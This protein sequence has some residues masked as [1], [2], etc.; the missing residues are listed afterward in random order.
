[1]PSILKAGV[2]A[3]MV[4]TGGL[5]PS[6]LLCAADFSEFDELDAQEASGGGGGGDG[7]GGGAAA[8]AGAGASTE[9]DDLEAAADGA[10]GSVAGGVDGVGGEAATSGDG[11][12]DDNE[13]AG[14]EFSNAASAGSRPGRSG[15]GAKRK[16]AARP[17]SAKAGAAA[18]GAHTAPKGEAPKGE[19]PYFYEYFGLSAV[20]VYIVNFFLGKVGNERRVKLWASRNARVLRDNFY[21]VGSISGEDLDVITEQGGDYCK[22]L[23]TK[24][25]QNHFQLFATCVGVRCVGERA[26]RAVRVHVRACAHG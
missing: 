10:G 8:A 19:A 26:V 11:A 1:M 9:F 25:S 5:A 2:V 23:L 16:R 24:H 6:N 13:D 3:L 4:A 7:G 20:A 22:V 12:D 14:D 18:D 15:G 21:Q 17:A